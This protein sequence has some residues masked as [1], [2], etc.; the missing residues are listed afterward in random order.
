MDFNPDNNNLD[1][2]GYKTT[3]MSEYGSFRLVDLTTGT[4]TQISQSGPYEAITGFNVNG[5]CPL[6]DP[7][8]SNGF[9]N[10]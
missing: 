7:D 3:A 9:S 8:Y 2:S 1:W 6:D 5:I 10:K 4:S